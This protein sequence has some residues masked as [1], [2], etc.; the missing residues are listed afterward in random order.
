MNI[1]PYL[2]RF[3]IVMSIPLARQYFFSSC[4]GF[5]VAYEALADAD[6]AA[7][8]AECKKRNKE[9]CVWTV[10][11]KE[12]MKQCIKWGVKSVISDKPELWR[13]VRKEVGPRLSLRADETDPAEP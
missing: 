13:L 1:L 9:I 4:H 2:P 11:L 5:S 6:G 10:N 7:F 12:E 8:R 3:A